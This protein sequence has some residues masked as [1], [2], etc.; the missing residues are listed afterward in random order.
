MDKFTEKTNQDNSE[1]NFGTDSNDNPTESNRPLL[2][3]IIVF[4]CFVLAYIINFHSHSISA[5]PGDWGVLGDYIGGVTNPLI[6]TIAL[7]YLAKAYY[8][9]KTELAETRIALRDTAKHSEDSARAQAKLVDSAIKQEILIKRNLELKL[10]A[11]QISLHQSKISFLH[12]ELSNSTYNFNKFTSTIDMFSTKRENWLTSRREMDSYRFRIISLIDKE[13]V[14]IKR[15]AD[16][17]KEIV[18]PE[19]SL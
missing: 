11:T 18:E 19:T 8:T 7:I 3:V 10:L 4:F 6:S 13:D 15:L 1:K 12:S 14:E 16:K 2:F 9:Q 17:V 5:N